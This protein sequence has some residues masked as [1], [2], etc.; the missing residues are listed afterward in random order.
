M[1]RKE[2]RR[3]KRTKT[4]IKHS[5]LNLLSQK[6]I[7]K[8]TIKELS[9]LANCDRK[10]IYN[11][12]DSVYEILD[13]I[14][15]ELV[16][17]VEESIEMIDAN[18]HIE[19]KEPIEMFEELAKIIIANSELMT[20]MVRLGKKSRLND[21][22]INLIK[23]KIVNL[24][25]ANISGEIDYEEVATFITAGY[26]SVFEDWL[27]NNKSDDLIRITKRMGVVMINGL[28]NYYKKS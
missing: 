24:L 14:E 28:K 18:K 9:D 1:P 10:T 5:L 6:S 16:A 20:Y 19:D 26:I 4:A 7:D 17:K 15:L 21:K 2:D 23:G 3:V 11:Y 27:M 25:K 12:Y 22:I 8:V 13:D